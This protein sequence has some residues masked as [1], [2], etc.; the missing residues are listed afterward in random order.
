MITSHRIQCALYREFQEEVGIG[1]S[2]GGFIY[3]H[4]AGN[5]SSSMEVSVEERGKLIVVIARSSAE[6]FSLSLDR[7][8]HCF[9]DSSVCRLTLEEES[10]LL[11]PP[12]ASSLV[13]V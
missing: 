13:K 6:V 8:S 5:G 10:Y 1:S 11:K 7:I 2:S 4:C 12:L 9:E 3:K